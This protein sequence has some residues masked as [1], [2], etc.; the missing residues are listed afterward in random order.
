MAVAMH[1]AV[2][3]PLAEPHS[4]N[5]RC[6]SPEQ[7]TIQTISDLLQDSLRKFSGSS[8]VGYP[9][10]S[11]GKGD[12]VY[13]TFEEL[14]TYVNEAAW[15]YEEAGLVP[16]VTLPS[17]TEVVALL[18]PSNLEYVVSVFALSRMGFAVLLL[19]NRLAPEA[20]VNLL[21]ETK[22]TK[23]ITN[24]VYTT[25]TQHITSLCTTTCFEIVKQAQFD[26]SNSINPPFPPV[27]FPDAS[28]RIAFIV[29]SS[30]S[31]GL[32]KPIF[33]THRSCLSNYS[34]GIPYRAF[35]TLPLFHNHGL[36]TLMR[37]ICAG[38]QVAM[39][40][41]N[42]PLSGSSLIEALAA[43]DPE[44]FHCVPYALKLL[45]ESSEGIQALRKC[46]LVLYGGSSCPD[47]LGDQ[48]VEHGVYLVGHYGATEMGQLMTSFRS[49]SDNAWNYMRP[50]AS[51]KQYLRM[52]PTGEGTFE[53]VVLEGLPSK[54]LSNSDDP[55]NSYHTRDTFVP[56]PTMPDA[57]KYLG[58]LDDRVTLV[59]GEKVLPVPYEHYIRQNELV[60][61][62]VIFGVGRAVPGLL[63]IP[64][65]KAAS[66][67]RSELLRILSPDVQVANSK[68]EAF[69]RVPLEMVRILDAGTQYP[70]TDKGTVIRARL[71]SQF[72][73]LIDATY[74]AFEAP[75]TPLEGQ[76]LLILDE[77]QLREYLLGLSSNRFGLTTLEVSTDFFEVGI[78]SLQA[79]TIRAQIMREIDL[80]GKVPGLNVVFEFPS[81]DL[82]AK[83]L[84]FLRSDELVLE[85]SEDLIM[86]RLIEKYSEFPT[87]V[88]GTLEPSEQTM[89]ITGTTGS[90]GAHMLS[91][92]VRIHNVKKIYCLVRA[93]S[94]QNAQDRLTSTL[95]SK[96]LPP[97]RSEGW[98]K[99]VCVPSDLSQPTLGLDAEILEELRNTLTVVIHSA[100]AV[101]FNMGVRSFESHHIRG[102]YNL[103]NLCL[104]T[105]TVKPSRLF[106][107]SSI[108][109]AAGTPIPARVSET[110]IEN[111]A[112]VQPIGYARSK[113][114]TEHIIRAASEKTGLCAEVLRL[115]Q[116][117]G[118]TGKG[119]WNLT[120]AIPL[121]IR[122]AH[123][124]G[125]LPSLNENP[126]WM[127]VDKMAGACLELSGITSNHGREISEATVVHNQPTV[128][129]VQNTKTFHWTQDLLPALKLAGLDFDVVSQRE[130]VARLRN[131]ESDPVKNP[132]I[133][134]LD[135]FATKYDNDNPGREGLI[136]ETKATEQASESVRAGFDVIR[137][138]LVEKMV[139]WWN[140][141][142]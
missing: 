142:W 73:E 130:W 123:V 33:Q 79:T 106:F 96:G 101:N 56:H 107:C 43:T 76:E 46:K 88:P 83:H 38:K 119:I 118:D 90:L 62:A 2:P 13:H 61:E 17:Q 135:F 29:H 59:N 12:F 84:H 137:S 36:S 78:D 68:A 85:D 23:L 132:T 6:R 58:R 40:N 112:H 94:L 141:Q 116:I 124:F 4:S 138:G 70:R 55:P 53:C 104:S 18:A 113:Y 66:V 72:S 35:V 136:F 41:S 69:G 15:K 86:S 16:E 64:S 30:G 95:Q 105:N 19:S 32:P 25:I 99:V 102:T 140:T 108:S 91:Q 129:Q 5:T 47:D 120:E 134:L 22:C 82:L 80:G 75:R 89:I 63:I 121:M 21:K 131:S 3:V 11:R 37:A 87:R 39:Y 111:P 122:T 1:Q 128:Y 126:S 48:L 93:S 92:A 125:A 34:S 97:L 10:T 45:A 110:F 52:V 98:G 31:T 117:I 100:W 51:A 44:S 14:N 115:G 103:L 114:V 60:E 109:A 67:T 42:L 133:K 81:I 26:N 127:P 28:R 7:S 54:V 65:V 139:A 57:W 8:C 50:L 20:Y 9:A 77:P 49:P 27:Y 24:P 71:Y 74:A